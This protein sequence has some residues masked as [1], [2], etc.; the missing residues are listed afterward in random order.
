MCVNASRWRVIYPL[1]SLTSKSI[2]EALLEEFAITGVPGTIFCNNASS[3]KSKL[4]QEFLKRTG[5]CHRFSTSNHPAACGLI[6]HMVGRIKSAMLKVAIEHLRQ[7]H[8]HLTCILW[9]LREVPACGRFPR[10]PSTIVRN[11]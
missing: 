3:F 2:Y 1:H 6:K 4:I 9:A 8:R 11:T 5:Y 7:W 10:G